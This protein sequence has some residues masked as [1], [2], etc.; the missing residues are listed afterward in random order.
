[1]IDPV[2]DVKGARPDE[3]ITTNPADAAQ[4]M[5]MQTP[6]IAVAP[7]V[8]AILVLLFLPLVYTR[9]LLNAMFLEQF[10]DSCHSFPTPH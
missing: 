9:L 6:M 4:R 3:Q 7:W 10:L 8:I 2:T 5:R 1:M